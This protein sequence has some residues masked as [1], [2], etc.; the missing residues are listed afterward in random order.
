MDGIGYISEWVNPNRNRNFPYVNDDGDVW[1][2]NFNWIDNDFND[3]W[4]FVVEQLSFIPRLSRGFPLLMRVSA[5]PRAF[6][7]FRQNVRTKR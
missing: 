3:N 2:S 7:R 4:R 1:N 5:N 6:S